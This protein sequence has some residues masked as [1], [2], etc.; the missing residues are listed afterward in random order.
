[1][2]TRSILHKAT[3]GYSI[4]TQTYIEKPIPPTWPWY[5]SLKVSHFS[6][7]TAHNVVREGGKSSVE[8]REMPAKVKFTFLS[9]GVFVSSEFLESENN[10]GSGTT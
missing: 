10:S 3:A 6:V 4:L 8:M 2:G 9:W 1:M 5:S 7:A